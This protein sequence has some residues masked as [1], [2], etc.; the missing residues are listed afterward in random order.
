VKASAFEVPDAV[1]MVTVAVMEAAVVGGTAGNA[2]TVTVHVVCTGQLVGATCPSKRATICP[3]GLRN[4]L[5]EMTIDSLG[6][7]AAGSREVSTGWPPLGT[8]VVVLVVVV[9]VAGG[10]GRV[11][12]VALGRR[13]VLAGEGRVVAAAA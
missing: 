12:G 13:V 1:V 7:P 8:A 3:L 6:V 11:V 9:P 10:E 2:G 5:P 4:P